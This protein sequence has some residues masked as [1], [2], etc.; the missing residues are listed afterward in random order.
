MRKIRIN[1]LET[2]QQER[3]QSDKFDDWCNHMN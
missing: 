1:D 2:L 3:Y